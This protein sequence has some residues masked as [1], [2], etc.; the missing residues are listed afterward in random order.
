MASSVKWAEDRVSATW[1]MRLKGKVMRFAKLVCRAGL[2]AAGGLALLTSM[3]G[4]AY[5]VVLPEIDPA[6][7]CGAV[8]LLMGGIML[9]TAKR[10]K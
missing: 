8:T 6:S 1:V 10:I 5:A 4:T 9:L 3:S 2:T 7:L